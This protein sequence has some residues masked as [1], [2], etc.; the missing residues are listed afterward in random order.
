MKKSTGL[1]VAV[2]LMA[3][4]A[5]LAAFSIQVPETPEPVTFVLMG[6]GLLALVLLHQRLRA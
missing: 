4:V 5:S 6:A 3:S 1:T 2:G